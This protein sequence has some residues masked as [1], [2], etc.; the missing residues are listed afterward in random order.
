MQYAEGRNYLLVGQAQTL[1]SRSASQLDSQICQ[2]L[3][4][5]LTYNL[6]RMGHPNLHKDVNRPGCVP[7]ELLFSMLAVPFSPTRVL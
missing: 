1:L 4:L 5:G 6:N 7:M 2:A 3:L